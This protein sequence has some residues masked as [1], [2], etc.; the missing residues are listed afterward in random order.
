MRKNLFLYTLLTIGLISC[1]LDSKLSSNKKQKNN[2]DIKEV[3]GNVQGNAINNLYGNQ[4]EQKDFTKNFRELKDERRI[5]AEGFIEPSAK[6]SIEVLSKSSSDLEPVVESFLETA[7]SGVLDDKAD[8]PNIVIEH[9]QKKEI[10]KEI[11]KDD[12]IPFTREEKRADEAIKEIENIIGGL[13][14]PKLIEDVCSLKNEY[15]LIKND[16]HEV[17]TEVRDKKTLLIRNSG[18]NN[19]GIKELGQLENDLKIDDE[20]ENIMV[21]IEVAEQYIRS[22]ASFFDEA[23]EMLEEGIIKRL[24]REDKKA[25]QLSKSAAY[26]AE[27]ALEN[28]EY[29]TSKK[30]E[31]MGRKR[32]IRELIQR[33]KTILSKF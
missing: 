23:K 12:L 9:D 22:A 21:S 28:L 32:A 1:N 11:K 4:E 5:L 8:I 25:A 20:L 13:G 14:F 24:K 27:D 30:V 29:Y 7:G 18:S 26:K 31:G 16:F 19:Y 2:K 15:I 10:K 3:L 17:K 6:E 33:A